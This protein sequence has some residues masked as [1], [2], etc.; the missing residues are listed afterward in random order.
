MASKKKSSTEARERRDLT[1]FSAFWS[2]T[3]AG[4]VVLF[5]FVLQLLMKLGVVITW[6]NSVVSICGIL[7][8]V[9]LVL[10]VAFPAYAYVRGKK[11]GWKIVF[12][13]ALVLHIMG[14]VG[15]GLSI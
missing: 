8:S 11:K 2:I 14:V 3:L 5:R 6:G 4:V 7:S 15:I 9:L 12:W 13:V 1:K 10:A